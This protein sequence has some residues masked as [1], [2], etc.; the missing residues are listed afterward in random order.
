MKLDNKLKLAMIHRNTVRTTIGFVEDK[1]EAIVKKVEEDMISDGC[2]KVNRYHEFFPHLAFDDLPD[3]VF[4]Q[5][6]NGTR[7][8]YEI[9]MK[10][11][12]S[13]YWFRRKFKFH[14]TRRPSL[15]DLI[16]S[17]QFFTGSELERLK[18]S[19]FHD[20]LHRLDTVLENWD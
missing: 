12:C 11:K 4:R 20:I 5:I 14:S 19:D 1:L 15:K 8:K 18:T 6:G 17:S 7:A 3:V 10:I 16:K 13:S 9:E 2:W